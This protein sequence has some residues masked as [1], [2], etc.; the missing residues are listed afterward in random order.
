MKRIFNFRSFVVYG[1]ANNEFKTARTYPK[2]VLI[3]ASANNNG[4]VVFSAPGQD[5][6]IVELPSSKQKAIAIT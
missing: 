6:L 1:E 3:E 4:E 2:L 5:Q